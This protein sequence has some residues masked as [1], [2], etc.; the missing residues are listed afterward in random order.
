MSNFRGSCHNY[1]A[2]IDFRRQCDLDLF[3]KSSPDN[4]SFGKSKTYIKLSNFKS[5]K[6]LRS[7]CY[8]K[9]NLAKI[10]KCE[11][12]YENESLLIERTYNC[13]SEPC[14]NSEEEEFLQAH[15][16]LSECLFLDYK[17]IIDKA[18]LFSSLD[19]SNLSVLVRDVDQANWNEVL[20]NERIKIVYDI[21]AKINANKCEVE[22]IFNSRLNKLKSDKPILILSH[23]DVDHFHCL[24]YADQQT[25]KKCF[26][27]FVC[28]SKMKS[29]T[30]YRICEKMRSA[31]GDSNV[32]CYRPHNQKNRLS[33]RCL[34][35]SHDLSVYIGGKSSNV[36]YC[37]LC[38]LVKGN[39]KSVNFTGD[40]RLLQAKDIYDQELTKLKTSQ[41]V[42]I[43]PHHG[44]ENSRKYR[45][46]SIPTTEVIISVGNNNIYNHPGR[47]MLL[48]LNSLCQNNLYR[49]DG[50]EQFIM[51]E[52]LKGNVVLNKSE[53]DDLSHYLKKLS[54][55]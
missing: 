6:K 29:L 36:N 42:L 2:Y 25:L 38:L 24:C 20:E 1:D 33:M 51:E 46:Y 18:L 26:S 27:Q 47:Q 21:G 52:R 16:F 32:F 49:T 15:N 4:N 50:E 9:L 22:K 11:F 39:L 34:F 35:N 41:H 10:N 17:P 53:V 48:Y 37:G 31:L 14:P 5:N 7:G 43:A 12:N 19:S 23:W 40:V 30:S 8:Y 3:T 28:V 55:T 13:G 45:C 54:S 44:G